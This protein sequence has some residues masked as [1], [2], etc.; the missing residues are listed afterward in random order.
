MNPIDNEVMPTRLIIINRISLVLY[1]SPIISQD[2]IM[3][4]TGVMPLRAP[5]RAKEIYLITEKSI[6]TTIQFNMHLSIMFF[7]IELGT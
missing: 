4:I 2:K 7:T 6:M 1:F 5:L 3:V